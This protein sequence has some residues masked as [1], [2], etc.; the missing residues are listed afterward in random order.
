MFWLSDLLG[1]ACIAA[2]TLS[3]AQR[4]VLLRSGRAGRPSARRE[5][6]HWFRLSLL[7]ITIGLFALDKGWNGTARWLATI[8][9]GAILI[10]DRGLWLGHTVRRRSAG[11]AATRRPGASHTTAESPAARDNGTFPV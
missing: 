11:R 4:L 7:F 1:W 5:M 3:A 8:A 10:L 2:G 9:A 6:W